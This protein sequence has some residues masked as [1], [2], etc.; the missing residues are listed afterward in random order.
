M[1]PIFLF[2]TKM[3]ND[4]N[5]SIKTEKIVIPIG[6]NS[7]EICLNCEKDNQKKKELESTFNNLETKIK[8]NNEP[9]LLKDGKICTISDRIVQIYDDRKYNI[10]Y[11]FKFEGEIISSIQLDNGDLI[12]VERTELDERFKSSYFDDYYF[13][14]LLI[15]RLKGNKYCLLQT[16]VEGMT[17]YRL[18][19]S[20]S[21]CMS[22]P[23]K[24]AVNF[25][26]EI[27]GNRFICVTNYGFKIYSLNNKNE[28]SLSLLTTH[29]EGIDIIHEVNEN[30]FIFCT[31]VHC[32]AS[33]GGPAHDILKIEIIKLNKITNYDCYI[34]NVKMEMNRNHVNSDDIENIIK[35]IKPLNLSLSCSCQEIYKYRT[36]YGY[37]SDSI[38]IKNKYFII[39]MDKNMLIFDLENGKQLIKYEITLSSSSFYR[40]NLKKWN[41]IE[42]NQFFIH[43]SGNIILFELNDDEKENV[44]LEIKVVS[45]FPGVDKIERIEENSNKFYFIDT[46][47]CVRLYKKN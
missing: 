10:L 33:L 17:G 43:N 4:F 25:I 35:E 22:Y 11:E 32:G 41:T 7:D 20:Y 21:G 1:P 28:Y 44:K 38:I 42:D 29:V 13:Y 3:Y 36:Y 31:I 39:M 40:I 24:Y 45:Y 23:K 27:S 2:Q 30:T 12:F 15:Y 5:K 18:Q 37:F 46:E 6:E 34:Q 9:K 8:F 14:Q 16:I 26:K 47:N 19:N